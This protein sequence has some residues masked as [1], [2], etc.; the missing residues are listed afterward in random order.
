MAKTLIESGPAA[1]AAHACACLNDEAECARYLETYKLIDKNMWANCRK[2]LSDK[3]KNNQIPTTKRNTSSAY[4]GDIVKFLKQNPCNDIKF[5]MSDLSI[6]P[7]MQSASIG[8]IDHTLS[9]LASIKQTITIP[10][11]T[12]NSPKTDKNNN[13]NSG[14]NQATVSTE[15]TNDKRQTKPTFTD[16]V[17]T[18]GS[19]K[20]SNNVPAK[21]SKTFRLWFE[22]DKD[23]THA[24]FKAWSSNWKIDTDSWKIVTLS[25]RKM[26]NT[27]FVKFTSKDESFK[28]FIPTS[29]SFSLY[30]QKTDPP[31]YE[32]RIN[33]KSYHLSKIGL[34]VDS[35]TIKTAVKSCFTNI[36]QSKIVIKLI[37]SKK[38][39]AD[40][41]RAYLRLTANEAGKTISQT[42]KFP[43]NVSIWIGSKPKFSSNTSPLPLEKWSNYP[44]DNSS[45]IGTYSNMITE[46]SS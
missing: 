10:S 28:N 8:L 44:D 2:M 6:L 12:T 31:D 45:S 43:C 1:I 11:N 3:F 19:W 30:H 22:T 18:K 16:V 17:K 35:D 21:I 33:V 4:I 41:Q 5:V 13:K 20:P 38:P 23:V 25:K 32:K 9:T 46:K 15:S 26:K 29:V 7:G 14:N 39:K 37:K 42:K 27:F 36:D 40:Y 34:N 24:D